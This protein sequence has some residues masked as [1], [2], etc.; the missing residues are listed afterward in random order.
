MGEERGSRAARSRPA[1]E[2]RSLGPT[3]VRNR[4]V[5]LLKLLPQLVA[6]LASATGAKLNLTILEMHLH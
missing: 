1:R 6:E 5:A 2:V 3:K 4:T